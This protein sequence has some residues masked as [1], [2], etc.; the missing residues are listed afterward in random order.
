M[1]LTKVRATILGLITVQYCERSAGVG[2]ARGEAERELDCLPAYSAR[3]TV[4]LRV[5]YVR[6]FMVGTFS[7]DTTV[8]YVPS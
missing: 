7:L 4:L 1:H 3:I 5:R 6:Y 2:G 8:K